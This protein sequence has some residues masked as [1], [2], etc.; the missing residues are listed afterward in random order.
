MNTSVKISLDTRK[1]KKDLTY[2]IILRITHK[3]RTTAISTGYS[4]Q[5][6]DWD[7]KKEIIKS[8]YRGVESVTRLNNY[9][10]KQ[11][12]NAL[13]I[14]TKLADKNELGLMSVTEIKLRITNSKRISS[15][16]NYSENLIS[17][18]Q[19]SGKIGNARAYSHSL[20]AIKSFHG[21]KDLSFEEINY[22][23]LNKLEQHHLSKGN[24]LNGLAV[25]LRTIRAIYNKAIKANIIDKSL[26]PFDKYKI[27]TKPTVKRAISGELIKRVKDAELNS[28]VALND[29]RNYFMASFYLMG[30]SF[31][32]LAYLTK[33][34]IVDGRIQ[35]IRRKTGQIF[36]IKISEDLKKIID[37]YRDK[38]SN[39]LF[40]IFIKKSTD[41][42][43][44]KQIQEARKRY[45]KR[46]KKIAELCNIEENLTSYV[47]RHS[48]ASLA[49]NNDIPLQAISQMMGHTS[50]KTTEIYLDS[51]NNDKI[52]DFNESISKL[53]N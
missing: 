20:S 14:I 26:Y 35:F 2:P 39:Y 48:F 21:K 4:V 41:I 5:L 37:Y 11:K 43:Q 23:F 53:I 7:K 19:K 32:D 34:N 42:G 51:L 50:I 29:A 8:T 15:F 1:Q 46:L 25:Y 33:E 18:L 52:D 44:Y 24:S 16:Y 3:R 22:N 30:I 17:E 12:S 27:K 40:P 49:K 38:N 13:E 28:N 9:L 10:L 31:V 6:K 47:S 36:S 45:N